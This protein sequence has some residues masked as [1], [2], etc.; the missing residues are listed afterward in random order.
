MRNL[1]V[2]KTRRVPTMLNGILTSLTNIIGKMVSLRNLVLL[3]VGKKDRPRQ[4]IKDICLTYVQNSEPQFSRE[5][6]TGSLGLFSG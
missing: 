3:R 1:C 5:L 6:L 2:L 4:V